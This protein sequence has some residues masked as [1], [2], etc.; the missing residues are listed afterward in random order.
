MPE[1]HKI[2]IDVALHNLVAC[3]TLPVNEEL[4][5]ETP[6]DEPCDPVADDD[7]ISP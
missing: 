2:V 7:T 4:V 5:I 3:I 1:E 6:D